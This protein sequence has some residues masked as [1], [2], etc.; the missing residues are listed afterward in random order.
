M[1]PK[2]MIEKRFSVCPQMMW[3]TLWANRGGRA[4]ALDFS[5]LWPLCPISRQPAGLNKI[6]DLATIRANPYGPVEACRA[7]ALQHDFWG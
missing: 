1:P 2:S 6:N 7:V 5:G 4:Q 3:I